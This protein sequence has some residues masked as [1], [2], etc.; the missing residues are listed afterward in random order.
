MSDDKIAMLFF[1]VFLAFT[2]P[3][4]GLTYMVEK[5]QKRVKDLEDGR[6]D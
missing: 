5:L 3:L 6:R 4:I 1:L 2:P